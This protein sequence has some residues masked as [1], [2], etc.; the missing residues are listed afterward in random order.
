MKIIISHL[1]SYQLNYTLSWIYIFNIQ[2]FLFNIM[3]ITK[4]S[5]AKKVSQSCHFSSGIPSVLV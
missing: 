5:P 1:E 3:D 4:D 2:Y